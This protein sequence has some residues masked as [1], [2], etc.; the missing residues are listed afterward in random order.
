MATVA[1]AATH[2]AKAGPVNGFATTRWSLILDA[3]SEEAT[4]RAAL[5]QICIAYRRPVLTYLRSHGHGAQ[6]AEDLTQE[7]FARLLERRWDTTADP[8]R[9]HFRAF[10]LTSLRRFVLDQRD[11]AMARKRGGGQAAVQWDDVADRIEDNGVSP[12]QAYQH[13]WAATVIERAFARL[14]DEAASAGRQQ[15]FDRLSPFLV[16]PPDAADYLALGAELGMR[17]NTIAVS[18]KRLRLRLREFVRAEIAGQTDGE[19]AV[20]AEL[21]VLREALLAPAGDSTR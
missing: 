14:R 15:L 20:D 21:R 8:A 13:A 9:G 1:Y 3:R 4:A 7:F 19:E 6:D 10:L 12:E 5:E 11:A 16:E 17:P 2:P 18:V